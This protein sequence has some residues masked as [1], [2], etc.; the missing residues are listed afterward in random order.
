VHASPPRRSTNQLLNLVVLIEYTDSRGLFSQPRSNMLSL[1]REKSRQPRV[2]APRPVPLSLLWCGPL[3]DAGAPTGAHYGRSSWARRGLLRKNCTARQSP[4]LQSQTTSASATSFKAIGNLHLYPIP[5][6][7][8]EQCSR[9]LFRILN[10]REGAGADSGFRT[11]RVLRNWPPL[12]LVGFASTA[13]T[14]EFN[15]V[16]TI[17]TP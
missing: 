10:P 4:T 15:Q 5:F 7:A 6:G 17:L 12:P 11:Q 2:P 8:R 9:R 3:Y 13:G 14:F 16:R 1:I